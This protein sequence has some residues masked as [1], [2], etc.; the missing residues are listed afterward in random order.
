MRIQIVA[1][2]LVT[3]I[4]PAAPH[5]QTRRIIENFGTSAE[6]ASPRAEIDDP[7]S[8]VRWLLYAS[9]DG[10]PGRLVPVSP[11]A[12]DEN[13]GAATPSVP[14]ALIRAGDRIVLEE[15]TPVVDSQLEAVAL[16]SAAV[17]GPL[18]VRLAI[19]GRVLSAVALARGRAL[20]ASGEVRP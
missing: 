11:V 4:V 12:V 3:L 6:A 13:G 2:I 8:G 9:A 18:R 14:L 10:G 15:H 16:S 17:G 7:S 20:L 1:A 19:G 5:A